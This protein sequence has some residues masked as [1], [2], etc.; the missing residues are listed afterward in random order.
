M[1]SLNK[2]QLLKIDTLNK[3]LKENGIFKI[4][5]YLSLEDIDKLKKEVLDHHKTHGNLYAFGSTYTIENPRYLSNTCLQIKVFSKPWMKELFLKYNNNISKGFFTNIYSTY[6]YKNSGE[7]GRNGFLH[8]DRNASLKFFLYLN[9]VTRENGAFY[10]Q[11]GSHKLGKKLR[12]KA[13]G[14]LIPTPND[15]FIKKIF[16]KFLGKTFNQVKNRIEIDYPEL[17]DSSKL[18]PV[19]GKAGTLIVFDSDIFHLGGLIEKKGLERLVL[20][21]HS[22]LS[23]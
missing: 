13:W 17:H 8:F 19:E 5:S 22:Y 9:D 4:E 12:E 14:K 10:I 3:H 21:M 15:N 16:Q 23:K 20:R 2:S 18:I 11:P 1:K 6:D 7:L